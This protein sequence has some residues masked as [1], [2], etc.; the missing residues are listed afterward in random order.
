VEAAAADFALD[1]AANVFGA[2]AGA[3]SGEGL[4]EGA[5]GAM[6]QF[7]GFFLRGRRRLGRV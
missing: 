7:A 5:L 4:S 3:G 1:S 2:I 6:G